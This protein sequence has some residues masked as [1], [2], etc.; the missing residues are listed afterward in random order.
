MLTPNAAALSSEEP[1]R[2]SPQSAGTGPKEN[3]AMHRFLLWM[4][5]GGVLEKRPA[6][7]TTLP[8]P[9]CG[10]PLFTW[11]DER[12]PEWFCL[13]CGAMGLPEHGAA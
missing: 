10:R 8:C 13:V 11:D 1:A 4:N 12:E 7:P 9:T 3:L 2:H 5:P 6:V